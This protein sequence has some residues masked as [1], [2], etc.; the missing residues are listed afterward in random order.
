MKSHLVKQNSPEWFELRLKYPLT[1]SHAQAIGNKGKGLE[2]LC[3][4]KMAEFYSDAE[5]ES[6][7]N[8]HLERGIELEEHAR[9][10]YELETGNT[11]EEVGFVTNEE[12]S[13][14]GGASPDGL[15]STDGLIEIK[16][17]AD[18]KHFKMVVE[19]QKTND[20]KIESQYEWQMQ[21]QM[22]FTGREWCDFVAFNPNYQ[23]SLLVKRVYRDEKKIEAIKEGLLKGEELINEIKNVL[24]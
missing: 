7:T 1:A 18:T 16:C 10:I 5:N 12:V 4:D 13:K 17:F 2:T 15:V 19:F 14:V 22:L 20:F 9:S 24:K 11:V 21:Q 23:K 6:Y 3:W 8:E